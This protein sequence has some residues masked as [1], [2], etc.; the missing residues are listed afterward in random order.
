MDLVEQPA[1]QLGVAELVEVLHAPPPRRRRRPAGGG[2]TRRRTPPRG[3]PSVS[4]SASVCSADS[5]SSRWIAKPTWTI[6]VVTDRGV[7]D[8]LP[9]RRPCARRRSRPRPSACRR[10]PQMCT[11]RPGTARHMLVSSP[12]SRSRR[13][14]AIDATISWPSARPPSFGGT[15]SVAQHREASRPRSW[16]A[17]RRQQQRVA[18]HTAGRARRCSGCLAARSLHG[19]RRPPGRRPRGGT[20]RPTSSAAHAP[21]EVR[22]RRPRRPAPGRRRQAGPGTARRPNGVAAPHRLRRRRGPGPPARS[23]PAPRS[24][25][26]G[27][28]RSSDDDRVEEPAHAGRRH[29][30]EAGSSWWREHGL[31]VGRAG[32]DR[33]QVGVPGQPG[34]GQVGQRH[35]VRAAHARVAAGQRDVARG[36]RPA[37]SPCSRRAAPRRP[38]PRRRRRSRCR[39]RRPRSPAGRRPGRA[40]PSPRRR[41]RGGAARCAPAGRAALRRAQAAD[42]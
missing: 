16:P 34:R 9:G 35:P 41:A 18:E 17:R 12:R 5:S 27:A 40:R 33:R 15:S 23:R 6:D 24:R 8:V 30:A 38:R 13:Q 7:G 26:R 36:G 32:R 42:R 4:K 2:R 21:P 14:S 22:R 37:G 10:V 19:Q 1:G 3:C 20:G 25:R 31:L 29:A 11:T 39:R 28:R